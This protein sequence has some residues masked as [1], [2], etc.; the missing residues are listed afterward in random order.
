[1]Y[2]APA[3]TTITPLA[4][5]EVL[6]ITPKRHGDA[7]GWFS[8]TWSRRTLAEA[9][10]AVFTGGGPGIME[11]ANRGAREAGGLSVGVNIELPHE[12]YPNPYLDVFVEFERFYVRKVMLVKYSYAFVVFPGGLGTLDELFEAVTL[13]QTGKIRQFPVVL[14]GSDY[15]APLL[16]F[17]RETMLPSGTLSAQDID[18]ILVTDDPIAAVRCILGITTRGFGLEIRPVPHPLWMLGELPASRRQRG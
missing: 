1:M 13:I 10:F 8:E 16:A 4:I 15:W 5:P 17:M 12:Q 11:A 14:M 18:R 2:V 7:R 9:G 3:M 6:L